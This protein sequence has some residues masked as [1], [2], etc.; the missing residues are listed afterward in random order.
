[1]LTNNFYSGIGYLVMGI[2]IQT[3]FYSFLSYLTL[4]PCV[5]FPS[6]QYYLVSLQHFYC[7]FVFCSFP[8]PCLYKKSEA[9]KL[10]AQCSKVLNKSFSPDLPRAHF[11]DVTMPR[12]GNPYCRED[13]LCSD[14]EDGFLIAEVSTMKCRR[15][16]MPPVRHTRD[17]IQVEIVAMSVQC[18]LGRETLKNLM[19]RPSAPTPS[20]PSSS[21]KK[22]GR[23]EAVAASGPPSVNSAPPPP[24]VSQRRTASPVVAP[25]PSPIASMEVDE[26]VAAPEEEAEV[27]DAAPTTPKRRRHRQRKRKRAAPSGSLPPDFDAREVIDIRNDQEQ[28]R[29]DERLQEILDAGFPLT[30]PKRRGRSPRPSKWARRRFRK[31]EANLRM[32]DIA[33]Q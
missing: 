18:D 30:T 9:N 5:S 4:P 21:K 27:Q 15:S 13:D 19:P 6:T 26:E 14:D 12:T 20:S 8:P 29:S 3:Q 1:M 31:Q 17:A 10:K 2:F 28:Q 24:D 33:R 22:K 23:T 25:L 7:I 32:S 11:G 16:A